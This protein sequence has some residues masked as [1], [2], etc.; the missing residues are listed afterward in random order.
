MN[1]QEIEEILKE[2]LGKDYKENGERTFS[3]GYLQSIKDTFLY[4]CFEN[5]SY[6]QM[7]DIIDNA[8]D[9]FF[10]I[11]GDETD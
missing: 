9:T 6:N 4:G 10:S 5:F 1:T 8:V 3:Q 11:Q 2:K 7:E